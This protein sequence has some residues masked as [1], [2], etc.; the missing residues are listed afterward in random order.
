MM[1]P[2]LNHHDYQSRLA[3]AS[4]TVYP[5]RW[6]L[7]RGGIIN[8]YQY[9]NEVLSFGGGRLLLRGANGAGK[10]TAMNMLLPFLLVARLRGLDATGEQSGTRILKSWM[11]DGHS[12]PQP[13]GY[14]WVEFRRG[15]EF[16]V[17]G[18]GLKASRSA[19]NVRQWWFGTSK[20]PGLD[21]S[22]VENDVPLTE[23]ELK[24]RLDGD[25]VFGRQQPLSDYRRLIEKRLFGGV[26]ISHH[27]RLINKVRDPRIGDHVDVEIPQLLKESLPELRDRILDNVAGSL[28]ELEEH[29][30]EVVNLGLTAEA[31]GGI[32]RVYRSYCFSWLGDT[33]DRC[34]KYLNKVRRVA[35]EN[36]KHRKAAESTALRVKH[37]E[38]QISELERAEQDLSDN[39]RALES[40]PAYRSIRDLSNKQELVINYERQVAETAK[41]V[42][43][44]EERL[45]SDTESWRARE[46]DS[47]RELSQLN[48]RLSESASIAHRHQIAGTPP[49]QLSPGDTIERPS[50]FDHT[51]RAIDRFEII[52]LQ[53]RHDVREVQGH[54][55][56][57]RRIEEQMRQVEGL[58]EN[59]REEAERV[60]QHLSEKNTEL[61]NSVL[62]WSSETQQWA[63]RVVTV[64]TD[65]PPRS[66]S[67]A[68][69][70][71]PSVTTQVEVNTERITLSSAIS[72]LIE[73][74]QRI[75]IRAE[76][77]LSDAQHRED[78]ARECAEIWSD[79]AE[80]AIPLL[81]WQR[82]SSHCL[83]DLVD[84][85]PTLSYSE[86]A[87]LEAALQAS[88]LLTARPDGHSVVLANGDLV[89]IA[90]TPALQ[91]LSQCLDVH[92]PAD[93]AHTTEATMLVKL[94]ESVS[95]DPSE[96]SA[97]AVISTDGTFRVGSLRGQ[98]FKEHPEF[99]G[100]AARQATVHRYRYEAR[101]LLNEARAD[102]VRANDLMEERHGILSCLVELRKVLPTIT[103]VVDAMARLDE[104][105]GMVEKA[106]LR[107]SEHTKKRDE[108]ERLLVEAEKR[109]R[110]AARMLSL[111][112]D[113]EPL[114]LVQD[115]LDSLEG[116]MGDSRQLLKSV[117][118]S[119]DRRDEA[120]C[121]R[122]G[123][124]KAL[125]SAR[126]ALGSQQ[127]AL[128]SQQENLRTLKKSIGENAQTINEQ[129]YR[130]KTDR[131]T[132]LE[133]LRTTRGTKE[134]TVK[135]Q[136]LADASVDDTAGQLKE[137]V[138][139]SDALAQ[140]IVEA[141]ETPGY[142]DT[143]S[144]LPF[145]RD[146]LVPLIDLENLTDILVQHLPTH[147]GES[148][149]VD[150][151][152][153]SV[154]ERRD[155]IGGGWDAVIREPDGA[156]DRLNLPYWV[157][158]TGPSG[159]ETLARA[160]ASVRKEHEKASRLLAEGQEVQLRELLYS[161]IAKE[162]AETSHAASELIDKMA[163][164]LKELSTASRIGVGI[165]W[166]TDPSLDPDTKRMVESLSMLPDTRSDEDQRTL[167]RLLGDH[168]ERTR[169]E[170]PDVGY[171]QALLEALDYKRWNQLHVMIRRNGQAKPL[172]R[173]TPLSEGE[174]KFV[175]YLP[176]FAAVAASCDSIVDASDEA[177]I[178]RF[179]LLDDAFAKVSEDNHA[180]LFG[181]LTD[182]DLDWI[183][184]SERLWGDYATI[185]ALEIVE[186]IRDPSLGA[187]LLERS[188]WD[189]RTLRRS[190]NQ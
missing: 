18:C 174:K 74:Q 100:G 99:I 65:A 142:W 22:L 114:E 97:S 55:N 151:V 3:E 181:L 104:A 109:L 2:D 189:S 67:A 83:A 126:D 161:V 145:P 156:D 110:D 188:R 38:R 159:K 98:H 47:Q 185:P 56:K 123:S 102:V 45:Q 93:L 29:H 162:A 128:R 81:A 68:S 72:Y 49:R 76:Q 84:F 105:R 150:S 1:L 61:D 6:Q 190:D 46:D 127:R 88:G 144:G 5:S 90:S 36:K 17:C 160:A 132:R 51:R 165:R 40:S 60:R 54:L 139:R 10:T 116:D 164:H 63:R 122:E 20:R 187:I 137:I 131:E 121:R 58:W 169:A 124:E 158:V 57:V 120:I 170:N 167:V 112:H 177:G 41:R 118:R 30:R 175:T 96:S 119:F 9:E 101:T 106:D 134:E 64:A 4:E 75:L 154:M 13:A 184:T 21:F 28:D 69:V 125:T 149:L 94:M 39:I 140:R 26:P 37:L 24:I 176:L 130:H 172:S 89:V 133:E 59:V 103:G 117:K 111:P 82:P 48:H 186:V 113:E 34:R 23:P 73:A 14:L 163:R 108:T 86:K 85:V 71:R 143:L 95:T 32:L 16:F 157:E 8:V 31:L 78:E 19:R 70:D 27:I 166:R 129:L 107:L 168:L 115:A 138:G 180:Q 178:V 53:R 62:R 50:V 87:G 42:N 43:T 79:R 77:E 136:A 155:R 183:V 171:K 11:L 135:Q 12:D 152:Y 7:S 35:R 66:I 182:L 44:A 33:T 15:D 153:R 173:R 148:V 146:Q 141:L 147:S 80:P 179:V 92:I 91:P 52:V 25:P